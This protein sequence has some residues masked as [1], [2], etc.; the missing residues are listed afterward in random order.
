MPMQLNMQQF[1]KA[2][3]MIILAEK[4]DIFLMFALKH[5]LCKVV[6]TS[7]HKLCFRA[8]HKK[9]MSIHPCKSQFYYIKWDARGINYTDVLT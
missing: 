4:E 5:R 2:V 3:K 9:K 7:T 8:K 6:L 1:F